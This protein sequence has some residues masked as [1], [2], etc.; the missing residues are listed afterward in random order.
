VNDVEG[1]SR[2]SEV[3]SFDRLYI[4]HF[5]LVICSN[6]VSTLH[7]LRDIATLTVYVTASDLKKSFIFHMTVKTI[8]DDS[9][10]LVVVF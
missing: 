7:H 1:H 2:S 6:D 5:L 4:T 8:G 9:D 10:S 3:A